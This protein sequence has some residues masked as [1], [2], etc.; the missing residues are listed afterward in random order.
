MSNFTLQRPLAFIDVETTGLNPKIDRIIELTIL[1]ILPNGTEELMRKRINPEMPILSESYAVHGISDKDVE[2]EPI[3][4]NYARSLL[5]FLDSCDLAG[6]GIVRFDLPFLEAEFRR[7]GIEFSR[8]DRYMV[9]AL[10][11]FHQ[12]EPR[13]LA[14]AYKKYCGKEME[15][16]HS[17][18]ADAKAALEV[19]EGQLKAHP[20]L[21]ER[22]VNCI[23]CVIPERING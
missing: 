10:T 12:L 14:A 18:H 20:E 2:A 7:C 1:K 17:S 13:D 4:R 23:L 5:E 21:P 19:L 16:A 6:F 22:L 8:K 11:I 15:S 3:F 9:D